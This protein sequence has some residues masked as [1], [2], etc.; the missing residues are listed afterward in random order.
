MEDRST[1]R[2]GLIRRTDPLTSLHK[3]PPPR[4]GKTR[5][6][7]AGW[8]TT[9]VTTEATILTVEGRS[10][11]RR[12]LI[13][14]TD[15]L[16]SL[17]KVP[18]T[19]RGKTRIPRVEGEVITRL[20]SPTGV[21]LAAAVGVSPADMVLTGVPLAGEPPPVAAAMARAEKGVIVIREANADRTPFG[22]EEDEDMKSKGLILV[23]TLIAVA[24]I[25]VSGGT[26]MAAGGGHGGGGHWSGGHGGHGGG[27]HWGGG[28]GGHGGGHWGGGWYGG[29]GW[30][31]PY[32]GLGLAT[33]AF[34]S[35]PYYNYPYYP[36]YQYYSYGAGYPYYSPQQ[37]S[38]RYVEP[39]P[40]A[41]EQT[42]WYFCPDARNYYP[43]VKKC[44][45]GWLKVIPPSG[46]A[47]GGE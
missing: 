13:P 28:H 5:I 16:T 4:R 2:R 39:S 14:R 8:V 32:Y 46:E 11:L 35:Y 43:Y 29:W 31:W 41:E 17:H 33:G 6:P 24:A 47:E 36:Y 34:L 12:G 18:P 10:M 9:A 25:L 22:R 26:V 45:S 1:L 27:G 19:R 38:S 40:Q 7:R 23:V 15:P 37:R 44:P 21:S 20:S 30:G 3:G 42:Y